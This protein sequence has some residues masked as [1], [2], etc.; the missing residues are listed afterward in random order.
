[1]VAKKILEETFL[2]FSMP[3]VIGSDIG[4]GFVSKVS[5][6]LEEIVGSNWKLLCEYCAYC[7]QSSG[8]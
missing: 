4:P 3:K 7:A 5:Q 6:G 8:R 2:R 1:M